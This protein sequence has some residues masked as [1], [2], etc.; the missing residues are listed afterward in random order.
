MSKDIRRLMKALSLFMIGS[1]LGKE[2]SRTGKSKAEGYAKTLQEPLRVTIAVLSGM[3]ILRMAVENP[4][5]DFFKSMLHSLR[6]LSYEMGLSEQPPQTIEIKKGITDTYIGAKRDLEEAGIVEAENAYT[7][8]TRLKKL[9]KEEMNKELMEIKR[10]NPNTYSAIK[11]YIKWDENK[12]T[13]Q[14]RGFSYLSV[15]DGERAKKIV[16]YL[17]KSKNSEN[18]IARLRRAG[19]ISNTVMGQI[20]KI[21]RGEKYK[22]KTRII[23]M[24]NDKIIII[25]QKDIE[26]IKEQLVEIKNAV[27]KGN[28]KYASKWVERAMTVF[29][30]ILVMAA[31]YT[32]LE[33]AGLPH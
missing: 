30:V 11:K 10:E 9:S 20:R 26:I 17:E 15:K 4:T 33:S 32:I 5:I 16:K 22:L 6:G 7:Y 14:E 3:E 1:Y 18:D 23:I 24:D 21:Q 27:A 13:R 28:N 8:Y 29:I 25:M 12:L 2:Y 31:L 19:I